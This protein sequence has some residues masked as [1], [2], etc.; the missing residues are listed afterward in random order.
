VDAFDVGQLRT[1]F[2][3][4]GPS[5]PYVAFLDANGDNTIDAVDVG[6]FRTRFNAI[7]FP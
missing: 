4:F 1:S 5:A 3:S 2:N 6:Q 7:L